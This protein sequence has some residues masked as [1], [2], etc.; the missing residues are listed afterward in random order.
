MKNLDKA[1][2]VLAAAMA[3]VPAVGKSPFISKVLDFCPAPGQFANEIPEI[4]AD[5]TREQANTLVLEQIGGDKNP[6]MI[7]LGAYGGYVVFAF[8]HPVVNV[9]GQADFRVYGNAFVSDQDS[10][11]GSCEPGI[12]MVSED[13]NGNGLP[14]DPWYEIAG[15]E[16]SNPD[17]FKGFRITYHKPASDHEAVP[18]EDNPSVTDKEYIRFTTN[19]P[20]YETGY[21]VRNAFHSQSYWPEWLG[22]ETLEFEGTRLPDNGVSIGEDGAEYWVLKFFGWGYV[23]N[24]PNNEDGGINIDWAVDSEGNPRNLGKVD[25]IKVYTGV[26]QSCGWLGET[27]TDICGAE[28]LHPEAEYNGAGA[29]RASEGV[30]VALRSAEGTLVVRTDMDGQVYSIYS[31]GGA[32]VGSGTLSAGD[33]RLDVSMLL[34]GAYVLRAGGKSLKFML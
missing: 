2:C 33:T 19:Q 4:P 15:S 7:S 9:E 24:V 27:S 8:D 25:F 32:F 17:T 1:F 22:V 26:S 31:L 16:Y 23:D 18:D 5:A 21:V 34:P 30:L 12:V 28:D 20:G 29:V 10:G 14:D 3:A 11:G 6:G 13:V